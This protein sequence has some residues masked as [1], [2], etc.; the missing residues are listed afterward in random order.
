V[1]FRLFVEFDN[2]QLTVDSVTT[3]RLIFLFLFTEQ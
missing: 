1:E 2:I 3:L